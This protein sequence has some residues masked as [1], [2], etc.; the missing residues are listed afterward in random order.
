[1][2]FK[3]ISFVPGNIYCPTTIDATICPA[4]VYTTANVGAPTTKPCTLITGYYTTS[5]CASVT[6]LTSGT[7]YFNNN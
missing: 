2:A 7:V 6:L 5:S 3:A 1:L 4:T